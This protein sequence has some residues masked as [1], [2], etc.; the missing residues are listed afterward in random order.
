MTDA[1]LCFLLC[2]ARIDASE[3]GGGLIVEPNLVVLLEHF[4][5]RPGTRTV[6]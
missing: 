4:L 1:Y 5:E 3:I 6:A 2:G